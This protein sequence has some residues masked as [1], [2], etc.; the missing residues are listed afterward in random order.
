M[1]A[2]VSSIYKR[3]S[4]NPLYKDSFWAVFGNGVG[5]FLLLLSG[6]IIARLLGKELY[7]EYGM[8]KTT[9]FTMATFSTLALGNSSTKFVAE[10]LL[11]DLSSVKSIIR[12]CIIIVLTFSMAMCLLLFIFSS[13]IANF[14]NEPQLSLSFRFLGVIIVF[15]A[16]NTIGAGILGGLKDFKQVGVNNIIAGSTMFALCIPL[17]KSFSLN[18]AYVSLLS[19]QVCLCILNIYFVYKLQKSIKSYSSDNYGKLLLKFTFPFA[20]NELV[21]TFTNWGNNLFITKYASLGD[22]GMLTACMQWNAIVLFMPGLL[23]NV[24][25]SYLSTSAIGSGQD[26]YHLLKRMLIINLMSTLIPMIVVMISSN[27]ITEY[28]G[29]SFKGMDAV[30]FVA[31]L[32][33]LFT[34]LSRVFDSNLMS[35]GRRWTAF[36]ICSVIYIIQ[37]IMT[38]VILKWTNG[39]DAAMNMAVLSVVMSIAMLSLYIIEYRVNRLKQGSCTI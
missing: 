19:S 15:R 5:N 27:Y 21:Y 2:M 8:V 10:Y 4:N 36:A 17:T 24:I 1:T 13:V 16:L 9:M 26:H 31:I 22:L 35:E 7:G 14:V 20:L 25:L 12:T 23:A 39:R 38:I 33:T 6:I 28:Y 18:G 32:G 29:E 37:F 34:C 11:K 3:L 30:L